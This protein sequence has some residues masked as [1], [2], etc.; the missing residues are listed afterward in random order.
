MIYIVLTILALL[1]GSRKIKF[2]QHITIDM[3]W[4]I[5]VIMI[6]IC[7]ARSTTIG[8]DT[9]MYKRVFENFRS[10]PSMALFFGG[11][12]YGYYFLDYIVS[13]LFDFRVFMMVC[14][15]ISIYP[16]LFII[17][18]HSKNRGMSLAI[19]IM[20]GYYTFCFSG[21][22]QAIAIGICAIAYN[23]ALEKNMA[24]YLVMIL[25]ASTFHFSAIIFLPVYWLEKI[26]FTKNTFY[27]AIASVLAVKL[28]SPLL[29]SIASKYVRV[30]ED[31]GYVGSNRM[32]IFMILTVLLGFI[33]LNIKRIENKKEGKILL[34]TQIITCMIWIMATS[35]NNGW[36]RLYFYYH[37][38]IMLFVPY[39]LSNI[40]DKSIK[41]IV[42]SGY[43]GI[44]FYMIYS[45]I[46]P[47]DYWL[48]PYSMF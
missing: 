33:F 43:V 41:I 7:G 16:I 37:I 32:I 36:A 18:K 1:L 25:L 12:D 4:I 6:L 31:S 14:S 42:S 20:F 8:L 48:N 2:K 38:Y 46:L 21:M 28:C 11:H 23:F 27:L 15:F 40:K 5:G 13:R 30:V 9:H 44:G 24:K 22:R 45:Q 34:Y 39:L 26:P 10:I 29:I 47:I 19:Y 35:Y 3:F 17:N